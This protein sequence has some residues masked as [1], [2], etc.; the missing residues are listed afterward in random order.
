MGEVILAPLA[1]FTHSPFRRLVRT[2]GADRTWTELVSAEM[3]LKKGLDDP[4]LFFTPEERP[5]TVQLFGKDPERIYQA[6]LRVAGT[7]FPDG[8]DLNL[9]C[10]VKKVA[11]RGAGAGL[12]RD[13]S[14]MEACAEALVSAG[15]TYGIPVSAKFRLG[16]AQDHLEEI[17]ERLV[18]A[19]VSTLVLH[20]RLG[21]EGFSG[22][23]RWERIRDLVNLVGK[24]IYVVG[25]G[26]VQTW[27]DIERMFRETGVQAV[28]VGRAA[29]KNPWIFR[30]YRTRNSLATG[31]RERAH[32][33]LK[34]LT[35]MF[36][37]F[38]KETACKKIKAL[39]AQ[40]FKG[41]PHRKHLLP[42]LLT[43]PD[44]HTL[45]KRLEKL[46]ESGPL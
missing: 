18:R 14:R 43:A 6:G 19:G 20:P 23:A 24:R 45:I 11:S 1:G 29:L 33:A 16:W 41:L 25:N 34:L 32:F 28:M 31:V 30:E 8:L 36:E 42:P 39:L 2:L 13:L 27:Q 15:K 21:V 46:R 3:I 40:L 4:L 5:I 35:L 17:A 37:I 44:C 22:R 10:S 38:R 12:L 9:G 26:D 7:L